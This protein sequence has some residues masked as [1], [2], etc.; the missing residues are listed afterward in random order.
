MTRTDDPIGRPPPALPERPEA[1]GP[2]PEPPPSRDPGG[3]GWPLWTAFVALI[4]AFVLGNVLGGIVY[5]IADASGYDVDDPPAGYLMAANLV[6]QGSLLASAL[7][8][9]R[10]YGGVSAAKLGLRPVRFLTGL[11][12]AAAA[13]IA[14]YVF[15]AVWISALGLENESDEITDR[16]EA[17][18][19]TATVVGIAIFAVVIAPI[20][21]E[22]FFRG[23]V[24]GALRSSMPPVA[25][26]A[27]T[28]LLFG[29]VH[30]FGSP[31]GFLVP[32][33]MLGFLLSLLYWK[34]GSLL[35]CIALH[36][37]NNSVALSVALG[38]GW[39]IPV[40]TAAAL[41]AVA[42]ILL[43]VVRSNGRRAAPA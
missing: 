25:A 15:Q 9:A 1:L 16:L 4:T 37:V 28:G 36:V 26:A 30:A 5:G 8:F 39:Q 34:T 33:A 14:Y 43:P 2:P 42:G 17:D 22:V 3:P 13:L 6:F 32:L 23:F 29:G 19:S 31:I 41:A 27:G 35:P 40:L 18:P 7:M 10:F 11:T 20:V 12:W 24:F 21:E 38:W